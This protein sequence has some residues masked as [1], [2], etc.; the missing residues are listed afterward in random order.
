M[1]LVRSG[2]TLLIK[3]GG[4][5][6]TTAC[7]CEDPPLP[8]F[9]PDLC[10]YLVE[11]VTPE[12]AA[13]KTKPIACGIPSFDESALYGVAN[14]WVFPGADFG[15][16]VP[17]TAM[18]N[19]SGPVAPVEVLAYSS[20]ATGPGVIVNFDIRLCDPSDVAK[21]NAFVSVTASV[22]IGC[23]A[24]LQKLYVEV[25]AAAIVG[26]Y[27]P[28]GLVWDPNASNLRSYAYGYFIPAFTCAAP[29]NRQCYGE[30]NPWYAVGFL[31]A[32][33]DI[34]VG[35]SSV[36][37]GDY[38]LY[39]VNSYGP[40]PGRFQDIFDSVL[41]STSLTFRITSRPSCKT[42][43]CQCIPFGQY[44]GFLEGMTMT[45]GGQ[46]FTIFDEPDPNRTDG[47]DIFEWSDLATPTITWTRWDAY[48]LE[49]QWRIRAEVFCSSDSQPGFSG[50]NT[51]TWFI[52]IESECFEWQAG[53]MTGYTKQTYIGKY[54]CYE[55]CGTFK[56]DGSPSGLVLVDTDYLTGLTIC[57]P[58]APPDV[59]LE[60]PPCQ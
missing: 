19:A 55:I 7:C 33:L 58:P 43:E 4:L 12:I 44:P 37:L 29:G 60:S 8:C 34:T 47:V 50:N 32:P 51:P 9:C 46:T 14:Q 26:D 49:E 42:V 3:N 18:T 35:L 57:D 54:D 27:T 10:S 16:F 52:Q 45:M 6:E 17:C 31:D 2:G 36:S 48:F 23:D 39:G 25:Q 24:L 1:G 53:T 40:S 28:W 59:P 30:P 11:L 13:Y 41:A 15:E 22:V 38:E 20:F 56:P 5:S 21:Q